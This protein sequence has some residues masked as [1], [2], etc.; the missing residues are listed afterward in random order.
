MPQHEK[1]TITNECKTPTRTDGIRATSVICVQ[2]CVQCRAPIDQLFSRESSASIHLVGDRS[3]DPACDHLLAYR[4]CHPCNQMLSSWMN[5]H[6]TTV[7]AQWPAAIWHSWQPCWLDDSAPTPLLTALQQQQ[8]ASSS[9]GHSL[10]G[11][12]LPVWL[13]L[14]QLFSVSVV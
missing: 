13:A 14:S 8:Q 5:Q 1:V 3:V 6:P 7:L 12:T 9:T 10:C 2:R 11:H 4:T